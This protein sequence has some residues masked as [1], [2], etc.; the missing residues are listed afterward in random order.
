MS[1]SLKIAPGLTLPLDAVTQT[2]GCIARKGA[3]KTYLAKKLAEQM[4]HA[5]AQVIVIDVVGN[6]YGLRLAADGKS[7]GF[8]IY[9]FG[10]DHGDVPLTPEAGKRI[11]ALV[12]EKRIS[13][14]LDISSFRKGER[15][16]FAAEFA[17]EFFHRKKSQRSPVHLFVEEAQKLVPQMAGPEERKM[18]GAFEDIIRLGR[19]YGIGCTLISQRPQSVNKEVL[20]QVE[21]LFCLQVNGVH[22]RKALEAWVAEHGAERDLV[23]QL[24]GLAI[25]EAFLWSPSWLRKFERIRVSPIETFDTSA[26]PTV[27]QKTAKAGE[28]SPMDLESLKADM[29]DVVAKAEESDPKTL[30]KRVQELERELAKANAAPSIDPARDS[31][32]RKEAAR[33]VHQSYAPIIEDLEKDL[34][35]VQRLEVGL[36]LLRS[37]ADMH[38][39]ITRPTPPPIKRVPLSPEMVERVEASRRASSNGHSDI[40]TGGLRRILIALAQCPNGL[41]AKQIGIRAGLSSSSGT[42]G[43]YLGKARSSGWIEGGRDHLHVTREG[44]AALGSYDPLPTGRE[45]LE[46]WLRELGSGGAARML[47]ALAA[48]YPESLTAEELGAAAEIS[49]SSGT[50][51]TYLGKL[52]TLELIS[53]S[54]SDLRASGDLF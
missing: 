14:V 53:G 40:G 32:I 8:P 45:L 15:E 7:P 13:V 33:A 22:E 28:L 25:G 37:A 5:D 4:L 24:P 20:S 50:F 11:A 52:R 3:G 47:T 2:I 41:S 34:A 1:Q 23:G 35:V 54:R 18:L 21:C 42:F 31:A 17:D 12:T 29:A 49:A 26:T 39:V 44:I 43:T 27:G 6:W 10:G 16:R 36:R 9:V 48:Q 38:E 51:G 30:R 19:N 46:H